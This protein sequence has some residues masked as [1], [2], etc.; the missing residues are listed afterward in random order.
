[1][2]ALYIAL[3]ILAVIMIILL[4][5]IDCV[6]DFSYN[7]DNRDGMVMLRYAFIKIK[8]FPSEKDVSIAAKESEKEIEKAEPER[9]KDILGTIRFAKKMFDALKTDVIKLLDHLLRRTIRIK[10]LNI[11]SLLGTGDAMYTGIAFGS[12]NA[13]VYNFIAL[14]KR[15][16]EIDKWNVNIDA[17]F[18]SACLSAGVYCKIRTSLAHILSLGIHAL[19]VLLKALRLTKKLK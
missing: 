17:D 3:I 13:A 7:K 18:D 6:I 10:E 14:L 16:T 8:L 11:S 5:N 1:M 9:D 19:F 4:I 12:A 15:H 2:P